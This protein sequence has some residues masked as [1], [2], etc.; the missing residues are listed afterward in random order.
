[1]YKSIQAQL[2]LPLHS[3][4]LFYRNFTRFYNTV[5]GNCYTFNAG[6]QNTTLLVSKVGPMYGE[7][8]TLCLLGSTRFHRK[9]D[10]D[11][12]DTHHFNIS[13]GID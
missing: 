8:A 6:D 4:C 12:G 13:C 5:Y 1:M 2:F 10:N 11:M 7:L 9:F 3:H